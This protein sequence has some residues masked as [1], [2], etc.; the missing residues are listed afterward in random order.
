MPRSIHRE[1]VCPY[2]GAAE[3]LHRSRMRWSERW[4]TL[5]GRCA[6]RCYACGTRFWDRRDRS[7]APR[8]PHRSPTGPDTVATCRNCGHQVALLLTADELR[9]AHAQGQLI[10]CP[11]CSAAFVHHA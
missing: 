5:V 7:I 10:S 6:Y 9:A 4:R 3:G 11:S 1:I 2:C 8:P